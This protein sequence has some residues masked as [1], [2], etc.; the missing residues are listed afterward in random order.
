MPTLAPSVE[1][2]SHRRRSTPRCRGRRS[3]GRPSCCTACNKAQLSAAYTV[4]LRRR[5]IPSC[6]GCHP[7]TGT[8]VCCSSWAATTRARAVDCC[9]SRPPRDIACLACRGRNGRRFPR[10]CRSP[11]RR[12]PRLGIHGT[13]VGRSG[14]QHGVLANRRPPVARRG[15]AHMATQRQGLQGLKCRR[16]AY[17]TG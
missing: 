13:V 9:V 15:V 7:D 8:L 11:P 4:V 10:C 12:L 16:D 14:G 2:A 1:R 17:H 5:R 6:C 3:A